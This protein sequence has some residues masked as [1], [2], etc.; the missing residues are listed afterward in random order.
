V[1]DRV[2]N[3]EADGRMILIVEPREL[4]DRAERDMLGAMAI[5]GRS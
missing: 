2:A 1:F 3:L 5:K 4:L